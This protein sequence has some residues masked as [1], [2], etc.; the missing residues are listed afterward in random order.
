[1]R[2]REASQSRDVKQF[3]AVDLL[4]NLVKPMEFFLMFINAYIIIY[5][6]YKGKFIKMYFSKYV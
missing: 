2:T 4:G 6:G 1:M 3:C 5:K